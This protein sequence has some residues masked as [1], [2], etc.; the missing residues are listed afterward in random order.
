MSLT[1]TDLVTLINNNITENHVQ[2]ITGNKLNYVL[3]QMANFI[4]GVKAPVEVTS[5][6]NFAQPVLAKE[7]TLFLAIKPSSTSTLTIGTTLGGNEIATLESL[8][9]GVWTVVQINYMPDSNGNIYV[10][11][12]TSSTIVRFYK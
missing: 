5:A 7:L 8:A 9:T 12:V 3:N 10:G 6:V 1:L 4:A 11:G 2:D